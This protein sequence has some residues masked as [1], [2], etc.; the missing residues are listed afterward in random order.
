MT[1]AAN[2]RT[3]FPPATAQLRPSPRPRSSASA[4]TFGISLVTVAGLIALWAL[5]AQLGWAS[6]L[7]LPSPADVLTQ[8]NAVAADGYANGTLLDHTLASLGRIAAALGI[9]IFVGIPLGLLMGLNRWVKG[10][11]SVPIDL[12][13]GLPPLAYLPLLIIWLGIGETSKIVLLSLSTFAPICFA[14][15]AGVRSVP[16][17]RINAALSLGASRLQLFTSIILPSALPE[18][19]TGLKIAIGAGLSTLVAA[20][21]IAAQ[22]GLGYMIMSAANFLATDVVFVGLI[23]IAVLA[24]A[25]TSGMRWLE[26]RL[27]PWKGKL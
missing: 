6:S 22:S 25:F 4:S 2:S 7:F 14:A 11:F 20:E 16:V 27:I 26:H 23:V 21:L 17:E 15:Q 9:G 13:W 3:P 10:I 19:L 1:L 18:I 24:F 8:F 12:Y 5:A